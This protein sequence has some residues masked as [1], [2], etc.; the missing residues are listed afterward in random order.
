MVSVLHFL[1]TMILINWPHADFTIRRDIDKRV[2]M[3][4]NSSNHLQIAFIPTISHLVD[5]EGRKK[6]KKQ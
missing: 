2:K 4:Q 3:G 5:E 6:G 1:M